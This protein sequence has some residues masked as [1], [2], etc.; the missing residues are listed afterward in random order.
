MNE[1]DKTE[2]RRIT[3]H[4]RSRSSYPKYTRRRLNQGG[5][6]DKGDGGRDGGRDGDGKAEAVHR[7]RLNTSP[8]TE[9]TLD[10]L[11]IR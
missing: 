4:S 6:D 3:S 1:L 11:P 10:V 7:F 9:K 8:V 5:G 2:T